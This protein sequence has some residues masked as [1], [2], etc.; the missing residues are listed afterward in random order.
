MAG[1]F[2]RDLPGHGQVPDKTHIGCR[3]GVSDRIPYC[4]AHVGTV[5]SYSARRRRRAGFG[6]S[7][8]T[9]LKYRVWRRKAIAATR[10]PP[11]ASEYCPA[12]RK[13]TAHTLPN[14]RRKKKA[15]SRNRISKCVGQRRIF[16]WFLQKQSEIHRRSRRRDAKRHKHSSRLRFSEP[17][18]L[19]LSES[20]PVAARTRCRPE[21]F[22]RLFV[23]PLQQRRQ[24]R[25]KRLVLRLSTGRRSFRAMT[26][27]PQ[28][29]S[30][31]PSV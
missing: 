25:R 18:A 27:P 23:F 19:F 31:I 24:C 3:S 13:W 22:C 8:G 16:G 2:Q 12:R 11:S 7:A 26:R 15:K 5:G 21:L 30:D 1:A 17:A 4:G 10:Q 20:A 9:V 6:S 14:K 29:L 28:L